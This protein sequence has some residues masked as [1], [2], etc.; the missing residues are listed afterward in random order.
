MTRK[1]HTTPPTTRLRPLPHEEGV[2]EAMP[3]NCGLRVCWPFIYMKECRN[4]NMDTMHMIHYL[5]S[6]LSTPVYLCPGSYYIHQSPHLFLWIINWQTQ[7]SPQNKQVLRTN[8]IADQCR[9]YPSRWTRGLLQTLHRTWIYFFFECLLY[10]SPP[11]IPYAD[12]QFM[13]TQSSESRSIF[14]SH[15]FLLFVLIARQ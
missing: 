11:Y 7:S 8:W 13:Q 10:R 1:R 9:R 4:S 12:S 2:C 6:Q 14:V 15:T 3:L 5:K